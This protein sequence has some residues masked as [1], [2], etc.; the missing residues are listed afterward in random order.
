MV[1]ILITGV[2]GSGVHPRREIH[3]LVADTRQFSLFVQLSEMDPEDSTSYYALACIH[4]YPYQ[5]WPASHSHSHDADA[6]TTKKKTQ[7]WGYCT[8]GTVLFPTWH[9][10]YTLALEQHLQA[11]ATHLASLYTIPDTPSWHLA[12]R[13][14]RMP[15]WDWA[16]HPLPP[17]EVIEYETPWVT[18]CRA[19]REEVSNPLFGFVFPKGVRGEGFPK[20]FARWGRTGAVV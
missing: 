5:P 8:H 17:P 12:A 4:G 11:H 15:Y 6:D 1:S 3:E 7:W 14:L 2:Q 20:R 13:T 16:L 10:L 19:K 9:R 18:T